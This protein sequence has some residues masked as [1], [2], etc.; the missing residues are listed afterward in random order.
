MKNY[1]YFSLS[2]P[3]DFIT[4]FGPHVMSEFPHVKP[5]TATSV[6]VRPKIVLSRVPS[7]ERSR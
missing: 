3:K 7:P 6:N 5:K 2:K 4:V 1:A